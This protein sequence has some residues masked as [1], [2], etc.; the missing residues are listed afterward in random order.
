MADN[1]DDLKGFS[2]VQTLPNGVPELVWIP[3]EQ[4]KTLNYSPDQVSA[5]P[6]IRQKD[7]WRFA[8]RHTSSEGNKL[9]SIPELNEKN[10]M[11]ALEAEQDMMNN[12]EKHQYG[13][14]D[15]TDSDDDDYDEPRS[16]PCGRMTMSFS[17]LDRF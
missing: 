1:I 4:G 8:P 3:R 13:D 5:L 14:D 15:E 16:G 10:L 2:C 6:I 17:G 7:D 12:D 11:K 9:D